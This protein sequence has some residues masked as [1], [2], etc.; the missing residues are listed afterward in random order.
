[1]EKP[2]PIH[3][4]A[5]FIKISFLGA[6]ILSIIFAINHL[7]LAKLF[8]IN[9][10]K[11]YGVNRVNHH[12][13]EELLLPMVTSGYFNIKIEFIRDRLLQIPWVSHLHVRR[14]WPDQLEVT[15]IEKDAAALWNGENL[16]S[17][18]GELFTPAQDT[19]PKQI[20]KFVGPNGKQVVMLQFYNDINRLLIPLHA[21]ISCLELTPF[22]SWKVNLD[23]GITL[24]I[25]HK[26]ILTRLD[27]FVKV[28]PK[29]IGE[30]VADVE[31]VD[32]RYPNGLAVRW[33]A[34]VA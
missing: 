32:L 4:V 10:V 2:S 14:V 6:I 7:H 15:I 5:Q 19:Y 28:Y 31:Y 21:K 1:M 11:V 25:G 26:D 17:K 13:V 8:P 24:H 34:P 33:K 27:H 23:N 12:E 20:P 30:H 3:F 29:I 18:A 9:T 16:L 22:Y